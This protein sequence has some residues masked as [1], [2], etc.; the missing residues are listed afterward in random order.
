MG[1]KSNCRRENRF[2]DPHGDTAQ[3]QQQPVFKTAQANWAV[4]AETMK[5]SAQK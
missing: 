4:A 2:Q 5:R 3:G 1:P